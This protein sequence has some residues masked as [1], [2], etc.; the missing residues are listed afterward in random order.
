MLGGLRGQ[1]QFG[2]KRQRLF[3]MNASAA[4]KLSV[5]EKSMSIPLAAV[6]FSH[7]NSPAVIAPLR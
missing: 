7:L 3:D 6:L 2:G 4:H 1:G 5:T